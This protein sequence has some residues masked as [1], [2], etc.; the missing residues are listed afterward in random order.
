V[1]GAL[2]VADTGNDRV[3]RFDGTTWTA[4][5]GTTF[6][7]PRGVWVDASGRL[8]VADSGNDRVVRLSG[9]TWSTVGSGY[10]RP[11]AATTAGSSVY[12]ADTGN[13]RVLKLDAATG[14]LQRTVASAGTG[15]AAV[16]EPEGVAVDAWGNVLVSDTGNDRI[17][18]FD[19]GG[20]F[21]DSFGGNGTS[22][23]R[24]I[25]PAQLVNGS[26]L[27]V[28]DPFNNRIQRYTLSTWTL[29]T[30]VPSATVARGSVVTTTVSV[31]PTG[32]FARPVSLTL[33]GCPKGATC[34]LSTSTL[35]PS[36]GV[37]PTATLR[38]A[39]SGA[40]PVGN[41]SVRV[42]GATTSPTI[43][44]AAYVALTVT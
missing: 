8:L 15:T 5:T 13:S 39:T 29:K 14:A 44:R 36:A 28:A 32:G 7:A 19:A 21:I 27:W 26:Y 33:S 38:I 4:V 20:G 41:A 18:R 37:Y 12:V 3:Q 10:A 25:Q 16:R 9:T 40:T 1:S 17:L 42:A 24:L 22:A 6:N 23:G 31:T 30:S 2:Y 34:T 35:T 43:S 11:E